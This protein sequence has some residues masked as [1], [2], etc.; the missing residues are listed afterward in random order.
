LVD[1]GC[2]VITGYVKDIDT[3]YRAA[4][5]Y[6]FPVKAGNTIQM[7]LSILEAMATNLPVITMDHPGIEKFIGDIEGVYTVASNEAFIKAIDR[8]AAND[9]S[10]NTRSVVDEFSWDHLADVVLDVYKNV[11]KGKP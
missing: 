5:C 11:A 3:V 1:A 10:P 8:I 9:Y 4:N 2:I 6:A 7:P